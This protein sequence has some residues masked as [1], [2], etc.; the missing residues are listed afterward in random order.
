MNDFAVQITKKD[1]MGVNTKYQTMQKFKEFVKWY[2]TGDM[3][4][5]KDIKIVL[6]SRLNKISNKKIT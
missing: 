6:E 5:T 1:V 3:K 4:D 2:K